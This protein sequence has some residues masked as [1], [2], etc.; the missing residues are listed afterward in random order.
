MRADSL[1]QITVQAQRD[2][3]TLKREVDTFR[4]RSCHRSTMGTRWRWEDKVSPLVAGFH[5]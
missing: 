3:E 2:R 1:D 5:H 4:R